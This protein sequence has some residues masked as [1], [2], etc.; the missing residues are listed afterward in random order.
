MVDKR[1]EHF[2]SLQRYAVVLRSLISGKLPANLQY[3]IATFPQ[4]VA[5]ARLQ[6]N[7]YTCKTI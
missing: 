5:I 3:V 1:N 2:Q 7:T 6:I 4:I